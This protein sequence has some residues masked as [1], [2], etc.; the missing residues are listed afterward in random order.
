MRIKPL[1]WELTTLLVAV[2]AFAVAALVRSE[3]LW[4]VLLL[5]VSV[6]TPLAIASAGVR[7]VAGIVDE[8]RRHRQAKAL[9]R[10]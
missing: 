2:A 1:G 10:R 8:D 9:R 3:Y 4:W 6:A 7:L 5:V